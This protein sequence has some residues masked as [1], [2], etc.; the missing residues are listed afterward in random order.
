MQFHRYKNFNTIYFHI[1]FSKFSFS[2]QHCIITY[3]LQILPANTKTYKSTNPTN[4]YC[5]G[6]KLIYV[7]VYTW[8]YVCV[9]IKAVYIQNFVIAVKSPV[10]YEDHIIFVYNVTLSFYTSLFL[11]FTHIHTYH[12]KSVLGFKQWCRMIKICYTF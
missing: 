1:E 11:S 8:T 2:W 3:L 4:C 12:F 10:I 5:L 9:C 6:N 7:L